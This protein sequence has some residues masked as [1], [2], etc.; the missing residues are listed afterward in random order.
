[1]NILFICTSNKD[2]SPALEA[3]FRDNYP[4]HEFRSAGINKYFCEKKGTHY[5]TMEDL[6]WVDSKLGFMVFCEQI[7]FDVFFKLFPAHNLTQPETYYKFIPRGEKT[8]ELKIPY[9][10]LGFGEYL[11]GFVL[12]DS[13]VKAEIKINKRFSLKFK[14]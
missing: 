5:I 6:E 1:M 10:I 3:Y 13:M 4:Q 7:H 2:R 8:H 11:Q 14:Y 12:D 9:I